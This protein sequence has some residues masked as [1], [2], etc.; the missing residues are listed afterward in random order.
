M[1]NL[2]VYTKD[3]CPYCVN[4]KEM[5]REYNISFNE[6]NIAEDEV[7]RS[8]LKSEGHK[9]VPQIYHNGKLFVE[10]GFSGMKQYLEN[11]MEKVA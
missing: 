11:T 10:G 5:L 8:F 2:V 9:T 6:I 7:A 3:N 4:L 1:E